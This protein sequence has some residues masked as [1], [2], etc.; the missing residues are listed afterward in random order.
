MNRLGCR[1][2]WVLMAFWTIA[3]GIVITAKLSSAQTPPRMRCG[4]G[5]SRD[6][7][8]KC[9]DAPSTPLEIQILYVAGSNGEYSSE[10]KT[11]AVKLTPGD[12]PSL[13]YTGTVPISLE[14]TY[15]GTPVATD[16]AKKAPRREGKGLRVQEFKIPITGVMPAGE[17]HRV[18]VKTK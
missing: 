5:Q 10:D 6:A 18:V 15:W 11:I 14:V 9:V 7:A 1:I 3:M 16:A 2:L 17:V 4:F 13:T 8:G 12:K